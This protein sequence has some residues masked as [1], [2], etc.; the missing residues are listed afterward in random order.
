MAGIRAG[1]PAAAAGSG[2]LRVTGAGKP[3]VG[4]RMPGAGADGAVPFPLGRARVLVETAPGMQLMATPAQ[5]FR[6]FE[7]GR[8]TRAQL[9]AA[10]ELHAR[11]LIA[12]MLEAR[13]N[14]LV[15]WLDETLAR[16]AAARLVKRHGEPLLREVLAVLGELAHF[17][18][19][20]LLWNAGHPDVPLHCFLR[21]RR[22]PVFRIIHFDAQ[23]SVVQLQVEYGKAAK[24]AAFRESFVLRRTR[25]GTLVVQARRGG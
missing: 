17:A 23:P 5:L 9:H 2:L 8:I 6:E 20:R 22:E 13:R 24:R 7:R 19:A 1:A 14:P 12:E 10:M 16:Q 18:P 3:N 4:R 15:A 11:E 25:A 21:T